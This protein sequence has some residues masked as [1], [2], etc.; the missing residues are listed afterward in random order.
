MSFDD[1]SGLTAYVFD[2]VLVTYEPISDMTAASNSEIGIDSKLLV[3][4]A[5]F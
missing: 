4:H 2:G 1:L 5:L 3:F